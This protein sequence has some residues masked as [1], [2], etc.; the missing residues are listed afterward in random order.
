MQMQI[1]IERFLRDKKSHSFKLN[2]YDRIVMVMLASYMGNKNTCWPSYSSLAIDA[3]LSRR[4]LIRVIK[5]LED[6]KIIKVI[7]EQ[8]KNNIYEFYPQV[9]TNGHYLVTNRH[10]LLVTNRHPNNINS[11]NI[12]NNRSL[13]KEWRRGNPDYDRYHGIDENKD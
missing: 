3:G 6:L 9:V 8:D 11:N 10:Q 7:R 2:A 5:K 12:I 4:S 1:I 13:I